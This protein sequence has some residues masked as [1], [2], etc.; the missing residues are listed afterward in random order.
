[1]HGPA[2][3]S[4]SNAGALSFELVGADCCSDAGALV[5]GTDLGRLSEALLGVDQSGSVD[6]HPSLTRSLGTTGFWKMAYVVHV[7]TQTAAFA[8]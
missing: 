4:I 5:A 1:M 3:L 7:S 2:W 6:L 8:D